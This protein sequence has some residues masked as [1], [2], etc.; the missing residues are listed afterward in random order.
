MAKD[1][2]DWQ[3]AHSPTEPYEITISRATRRTTAIATRRKQDCRL[4]DGM[5]SE[6][7]S[8]AEAI[9][10]AVALLAGEVGMAR[11]SFER[12]DRGWDLMTNIDWQRRVLDAYKS[13]CDDTPK[14][15]LRITIWVLYEGGSPARVD[16]AEHRRNGWAKEEVHRGIEVYLE[17]RFRRE[18]AE[19]ITFDKG[20][21]T[22]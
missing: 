18:V 17:D 10:I 4:W 11:S 22:C 13:W 3:E 8:A 2:L 6:M 5:T 9:R 15:T 21:E 14:T 7:E 1:A 20:G 16:R 12:L 19:T